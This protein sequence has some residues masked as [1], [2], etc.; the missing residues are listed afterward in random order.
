VANIKAQASNFL[1]MSLL[2]WSYIIVL[3][4]LIFVYELNQ[5]HYLD[6]SCDCIMMISFSLSLLKEWIGDSRGCKI[7]YKHNSKFK[8][9]NIKKCILIF[10]LNMNKFYT[11]HLLFIYYLKN[12]IKNE[13]KI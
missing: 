11:Y 12:E 9:F 2:S 7:K 13:F 5:V 4:L 6:Y 3:D 8:M 10:Y 1:S